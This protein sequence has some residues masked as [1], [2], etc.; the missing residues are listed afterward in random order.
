MGHLRRSMVC[1]KGVNF[2]ALAD[3]FL[4]TR[5]YRICIRPIAHTPW[6]EFSDLFFSDSQGGKPGTQM[7]AF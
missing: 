5:V 1:V 4:R 6:D 7:A 2:T 3:G